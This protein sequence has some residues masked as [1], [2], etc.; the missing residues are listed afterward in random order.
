M[1][2]DWKLVPIPDRMKSLDRDK[3][4]Y[5]VPYIVLRGT[6]GPV[7]AA[8][9][10]IRVQRC[11][12]DG[13]CQI[14]GQQMT[15][16]D[17]WLVGGPLS[18]FHPNGAFLD[19]ACHYDCL[20]YALIVCP[21]LAAPNY[22]AYNSPEKMEEMRA[23]GLIQEEIAMFANPT[24][25]NDRPPF[26]VAVQITGLAVHNH[27]HTHEGITYMERTLHPEQPYLDV[28][29]WLHGEQIEQTRAQ[30]LWNSLSDYRVKEFIREV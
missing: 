24:M 26:F 1:N 19:P 30:E 21:Y 6:A 28:Q 4:G 9:D 16:K 14:C 22:S 18:A 11:L 23:K 7:F 17:C 25:G 12:T 5:P 13:L 3:R 15:K 20:Q 2:K 27:P 8:N 10:E 29:Y